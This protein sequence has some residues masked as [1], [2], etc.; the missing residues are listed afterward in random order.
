MY[1]DGGLA[2]EALGG[3]CGNVLL[4]LAM[5]HRN[6]APVLA[7]GDDGE[8]ERLINEFIQAGA[9]VEYIYRRPGLRS[10]VLAQTLN[11]SL[12]LHS[13]SFVCPETNEDFPRYHPIGELE[14]AQALPVLTNC[15][16]FYV[17]RLSHGILEALKIARASGAV[18]FFE[19]S[20][21]E[22]DHL[23]E[24][25]ISLCSILKYSD[26]RLGERLADEVTDCVRIVTYGAAGLELRDA[27]DVF[28]C[29]SFSAPAVVDTCGSGDMVSVGVID[30]LLT[31]HLSSHALKAARLLRGVTAGQ[32]LAA[33]NC[34]FAGARGLFRHRDA[35]YVRSLL[36][37]GGERYSAAM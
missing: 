27:T 24:E 31:N 32:R 29:P 12:G 3:S 23:F 16:V 20:K 18:V 2:G 28:W 30:W 25:A 35:E 33:E 14:L 1:T 4:S 5:L 37:E 21:I 9:V 36:S 8:G 6:V 15:S 11:P 10:P 22:D 34:A 13:F 7:L 19:P 17:D 26:D